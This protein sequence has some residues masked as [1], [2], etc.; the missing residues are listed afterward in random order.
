MD[1]IAQLVEQ[2]TSKIH[3]RNSFSYYFPSLQKWCVALLLLQ[4]VF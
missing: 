2:C 3:V 1:W 4:S